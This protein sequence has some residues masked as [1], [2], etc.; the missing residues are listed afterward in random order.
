MKYE[1]QNSSKTSSSEIT[2]KHF[3]NNLLEQPDMFIMFMIF[4]FY[5]LVC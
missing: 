1:D 4:F 5:K 3:I 2:S